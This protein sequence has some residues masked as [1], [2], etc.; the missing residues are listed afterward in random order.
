MEV[1]DGVVGVLQNRWVICRDPKSPRDVTRG[2]NR[3]SSSLRSCLERPRALEIRHAVFDGTAAV[4]RPLSG[5]FGGQFRSRRH[6]E[7]LE[8]VMEVRLNRPR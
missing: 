6:A 1:N 5:R 4:S 2:I 7:L 3:D 8:N